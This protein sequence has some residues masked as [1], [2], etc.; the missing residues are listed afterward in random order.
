M[1]PLGY[2]LYTFGLLGIPMNYEA[3]RNVQNQLYQSSINTIELFSVVF[4]AGMKVVSIVE[5]YMTHV[6]GFWFFFSCINRYLHSPYKKTLE[7]PRSSIRFFSEPAANYVLDDLLIKKK[8]SR[9]TF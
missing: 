7:L 2:T 1:E 3:G 9:L 4:H 8:L 6:K 5:N